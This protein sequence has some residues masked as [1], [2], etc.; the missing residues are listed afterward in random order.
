MFP[1]LFSLLILTFIKM[2]WPSAINATRAPETRDRLTCRSNRQKGV[3]LS[4][5]LTLVNTGAHRKYSLGLSSFIVWHCFWF[6][7]N[8]FTVLVR[9]PQ[10]AALRVTVPM[11]LSHGNNLSVFSVASKLKRISQTPACWTPTL[12][13]FYYCNVDTF[14][15]LLHAGAGGWYPLEQTD[16]MHSCIPI[17]TVAAFEQNSG[18][19]NAYGLTMFLSCVYHHDSLKTLQH[20][21]MQLF[22][23]PI[24]D[25]EG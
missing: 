16:V 4:S 7:T 21:V 14:C 24:Y 2:P 23:K 18:F 10:Q 20:C 13:C 12:C 8:N 5:C 17:R 1:P 9:Q 6:C 15:L 22:T 11:L 3:G 19:I 25:T